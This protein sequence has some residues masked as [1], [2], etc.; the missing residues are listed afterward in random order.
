MVHDDVDRRRGDGLLHGRDVRAEGRGRRAVRPRGRVLRNDPR[1]R[2]LARARTRASR[3]T[4][5]PTRARP[6]PI[7]GGVDHF[8]PPADIEA[9]AGRVGRPTRLRDRRVPRGAEHGFIHAPERPSHRADDAA[10][11]WTASSRFL[12]GLERGA[13][14]ERLAVEDLVVASAFHLEPAEAGEQ[15]EGLVHPLA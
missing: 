9:L 3:S 7:F 15:G 12:V 4:P 11:A 14:F 13:V 5:S 8:T 2:G 10:D 6:S 1:A